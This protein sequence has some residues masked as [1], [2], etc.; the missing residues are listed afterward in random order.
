MLSK[1]TSCFNETFANC[2]G[3]EESMS[4]RSLKTLLYYSTSSLTYLQII[5]HRQ[6][7]KKEA[8]LLFVVVSRKFNY[9]SKQNRTKTSSFDASVVILI[10]TFST[11]Q[12]LFICMKLCVKQKFFNCRS[13]E[14]RLKVKCSSCSQCMAF[15]RDQH[16]VSFFAHVGHSS[17]QTC[18]SH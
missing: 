17:A 5:L 7:G 6:N 10:E 15:L 8:K 4:D 13:S 18:Y 1:Q 11:L 14:I 9:Y 3:R 12:S 2:W 16:S